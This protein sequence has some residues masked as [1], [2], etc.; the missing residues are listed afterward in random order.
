VLSK[1]RTDF[2]DGPP[3]M[4]FSAAI[5][6]PDDVL[7]LRL[8]PPGHAECKCDSGFGSFTSLGSASP[9]RRAEEPGRLDRTAMNWRAT[10]P[11][12]APTAGS[13]TVLYLPHS[14]DRTSAA[15]TIHT[16]VR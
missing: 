16:C 1:F 6:G 11:T 15:R 2:A 4:N 5:D 12:A 9:P 10:R 13:I 8:E 7:V 14:P 3:Y